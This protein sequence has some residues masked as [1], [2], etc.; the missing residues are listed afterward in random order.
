MFMHS[1]FLVLKRTLKKPK[2]ICLDN[3][4]EVDELIKTFTALCTVMK[5]WMDIVQLVA[6]LEEKILWC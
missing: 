2:I 1:T 5:G 3:K 6:R 4:R